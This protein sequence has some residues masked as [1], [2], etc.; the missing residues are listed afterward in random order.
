MGP[1]DLGARLDLAAA[2]RELAPVVARLNELLNR[3]AA[4]FEREKCFT[5][6][7]AHEL[8]T[9]LAGLAAALEVCANERRE[10]PHYERV[11]GECL[12]VVRQM[13]AMIDNLLT[14]A[15]AD[16]GRVVVARAPVRLGQLVRE[17]WSFHA[18]RAAERRLSVEFDVDDDA[19]IDTDGEKLALVLT[20]L[21]ANAVQYADDAGTVRVTARATGDG[22]CVRV[23]NT[24][25]RVRAEDAGRVFDRFWRGDAARG[26]AGGRNCGLGLA[27][28][29]KLA[30]ALGATIDATTARGGWFAVELRL[31]IP[32]RRIPGAVVAATDDPLCV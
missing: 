7:A 25:S 19:V 1:T 15:R 30:A 26:N 18:P 17:A 2:P 14:L 11:V 8:R 9:P 5:S 31:P 24:G 27:V 10:P 20:N 23:A 16:A 32:A 6:D 29:R 22:V 12:R 4:A 3:L 21:L 13:H 28:C